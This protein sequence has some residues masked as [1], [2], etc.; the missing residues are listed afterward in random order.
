MIDLDGPRVIRL[1]MP[2]DQHRSTL[3]DHIV[4]GRRWADV[5]WSAD[6][7]QLAFVSTSRDH[8]HESVRVADAATGAVRDVLQEIG[9]D[10][11][12]V[13]LQRTS[14]WQRARRRLNELIWYS[15]RDRLGPPLPVRPRVPAR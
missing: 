1:Q 14:N 6:G 2:P 5:D 4:C 11:L 9:F 13:R 8:Q 10:F 15:E 3:C 7:A 12:R